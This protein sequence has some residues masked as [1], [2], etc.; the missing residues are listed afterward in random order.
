MLG[1][2]HAAA[3]PLTARFGIVHGHAVGLMLPHVV[4]FNAELADIRAVYSEL[5]EAAGT[6][7]LSERPL[8]P[9]FSPSDGDRVAVGPCEGSVE[10][11]VER[12]KQLL[13]CTSLPQT[14]A[15]AGVERQA[16]PALAE[17]AAKQWTAGFNPRSIGVNDFVGLYTAAL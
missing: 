17:E 15:A 11:L 14:L 9:S 2:A 7:S 1:A 3:N 5:A 8:T 16:I 6:V 10:S 12:L 13:A 4:R